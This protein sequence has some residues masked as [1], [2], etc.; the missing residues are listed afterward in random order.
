MA[1][2]AFVMF[3]E[4]DGTPVDGAGVYGIWDNGIIRSILPVEFYDMRLGAY[5]EV[6]IVREKISEKPRYE[7]YDKALR[8]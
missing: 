4:D 1:L 7:S 5:I 3:K 8:A 2:V 6:P